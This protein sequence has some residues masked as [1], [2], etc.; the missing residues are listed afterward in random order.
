M[1]NRLL[2][3]TAFALLAWS[4][5]GGAC[6][7]GSS[8]GPA[9]TLEQYFVRLQEADN[10][11]SAR[12]DRL[13]QQLEAP[14]PEGLALQTLKDVMPGQ[15]ATLKDLV[16]AMERLQPPVEVEDAHKAAVAALKLTVEATQKEAVAIE[17]ATSLSEVRDVLNGPDTVAATQKTSETCLALEQ[18]GTERGIS[19]DLD[20]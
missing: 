8:G 4:V 17:G 6:G 12:I 3:V 1:N 16:G 14:G 9:L 19:V 15:V 10:Q 11:A 20:C 2:G 7:G 5:L 18:A 13:G